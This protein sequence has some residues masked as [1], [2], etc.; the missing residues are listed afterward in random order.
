MI[1]GL[2]VLAKS[3]GS[4]ILA[5][6]I[7]PNPQFEKYFARPQQWQAEFNALRH[8]LLDCQLTEELK[9]RQ[10]CYTFD[11]KNIVILS[12]FKAFCALGFFQG[13]L[14]PDPQGRLVAPGPNSRAAK[15]LRFTAMAD[16]ADSKAVIAEYVQAAIT[17]SRSGAKVDFSANK[18]VLYPLELD[19]AFANDNDFRAA[20]EALTPGRQRG[21]VLQFET[22]RQS[23]TR[24][25]RI[26]K[27]KDS[28]LRG[29]GPHDD[30]KKS[31]VRR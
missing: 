20:F 10:P 16:I 23:A 14:L 31:R 19:A 30:Y 1:D 2:D 17:I 29:L 11:G 25:A 9:W 6:M 27:A 28:I 7:G 26:A 3:S 13:S 22:A 15:M 24:V 18:T 4:D 12:G 21:W 8:I 5:V